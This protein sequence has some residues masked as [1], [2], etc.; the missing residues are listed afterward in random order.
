MILYVIDAKE[1]RKVK[2]ST[3]LVIDDDVDIGDLMERTLTHA[4]HG[5]IRAYSGTEALLR[6]KSDRPDLVLLDLMLPGISG[7][8]LLTGIQEVP[9]IVVSAKTDISDKVKLLMDGAVDYITKPFDQAELLARVEVHLRLR[10]N[11]GRNSSNDKA[12]VVNI[13]RYGALSLDTGACVVRI[14]E[15]QIHLTR[16]EYAILKCLME[17]AG[18]VVTKSGILDHISIDTPDCTDDSLKMHVSNLRK[19]LREVDGNDYIESVWGIGFKLK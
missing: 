12:D 18:R 5:V 8:E 3:I 17:N 15:S 13:L 16:T 6:L 2:M 11:P 4:G 19:K 9:V 14:N 10:D 1:V 7:E